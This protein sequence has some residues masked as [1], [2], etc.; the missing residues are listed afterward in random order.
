LV[1]GHVPMRKIL[2]VLR[3]HFSGG[4]S[5]QVIAEALRISKGSV[6]NCLKR[7][8]DSGLSWPLP[9][10]FT[11]SALK[12]KLYPSKASPSKLLS[13]DE[14]DRFLAELK[15][16]H[17]TRRLL[18]KE[19]RRE[20]PQGLGRTQFYDQIARHAEASKVSLHME[21]AG[22]DKLFIDYSGDKPSYLDLETGEV[23]PECAR[24]T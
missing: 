10:G 13:K 1:R 20:N 5:N 14:L 6:F 22:G 19:Y 7:F 2:D 8:E 12:E 16:P 21:H 17:V 4:L 3:L 18:F 15:R 23:I 9:E 11:Q 24:E